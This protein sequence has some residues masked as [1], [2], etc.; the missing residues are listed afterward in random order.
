MLKGHQ[1]LK[2]SLADFSQQHRLCLEVS[3]ASP[4]PILPHLFLVAV[5]NQQMGASGC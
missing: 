5:Y 1:M 2:N 4:L 3:L